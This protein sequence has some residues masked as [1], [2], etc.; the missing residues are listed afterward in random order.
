MLNKREN[1]MENLIFQKRRS[2]LMESIEPGSL[3]IMRGST[4]QHIYSGNYRP[5][6]QNSNFYYLTGLNEPNLMLI[7]IKTQDRIIEN[8]FIERTDKHTEKWDR[9]MLR[10][11]EIPGLCAIDKTYYIDEVLKVLNMYITSCESIF[12]DE[13]FDNFI[14]NKDLHKDIIQNIRRLYPS[15]IFYDIQKFISPLRIVKEDYE[16]QCIKKAIDITRQA[17][18]EVRSILKEGIAENEILGHILKVFLY[19]NSF[20]TFSPIVGTGPS[21]TILHYDKNNRKS[22]ENELVLIDIGADWKLY[23]SDITRTLPISGKF[24]SFQ[25]DA[26]QM[27][28]EV[29]KFAFSI[30]KPGISLHELNTKVREYQRSLYTKNN[31]AESEEKANDIIVHNVSHYLGL[32]P[33]D[34]G[35]FHSPLKPN[36]VITVEPGIYIDEKELG[37]RIEDDIMITEDGCINL[38]SKI[39]KEIEDIS[40]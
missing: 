20:A 30:A 19:N 3:V 23:S 21:A 16:I 38:S 25:K 11:E 17:L 29:Q 15:K 27:L 2:R 33:H 5:F 36:T 18:D 24:T 14:Y 9:K 1:M 26:Y 10:K 35:D 31:F 34:Y 4:H 37:I 40:I 22:K 13:S 8:L 32:D 28:L 12:I 39:K 6:R 7:L